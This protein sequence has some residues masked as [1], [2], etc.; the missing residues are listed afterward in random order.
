MPARFVTID[1]DTPMLLPPDLRDWVPE[2]HLVHFVM[3]AVGLL[4]LSTAHINHGGTGSEQYPPSMMLGLLIYC[5]ASGTFSSRRIERLTHENVAVRLLCADTHPDHDSLCTFRRENRALLES[6]FHQV[7]EVAAR[8]RVLRVGEVTLAVD[9]TKIL[10]NASK[11]SAVSHGHAQRQM[12][13][14]EEQI[15]EL[16]AKADAADSAPL[17]D[18]LTVPGEIARRRDRIE[19]LRAATAVIAARAKAR[20][21]EEL[22]TFEA[23]QR[24]REERQKGTG[25]KPR[26]RAPKPPQEG[27]R[28]KDQYNFTDPESRVM[29]TADGFQQTYNAQAAVEIESRLLVSAAVTDAP[30]DKEQLVPTLGAVSPVIESLG[31]VLI[32]S[33]FYSATAVAAAEQSHDGRPAPKIY[34]ATG[35]QP[36]GRSVAQLEQRAD[37]PALGADASAQEIM[38]HRLATRAGRKL[39]AQ[40]KQTI[41]PVFGIIKAAMGFRRFSLRGL[42]KV[43]T[44]WTLVTLAYNLKRLFH[45]G[46]NLAAA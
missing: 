2:D 26:G 25:Q 37:P 46:A 35:R 39:Y 30:N 33:G 6:S 31:A 3:D 7:L 22:A 13:L 4:D 19:K 18:G 14:L 45:V 17:E 11:H 34:A 12:V 23:Q 1:H 38:A 10:A 36:H 24:V 40:R 27:P 21:R 28:A 29:K 15:A 20:Q 16:L 41:E 5:Y 42:A 44:E 9:G 8:L 32:D 43:H